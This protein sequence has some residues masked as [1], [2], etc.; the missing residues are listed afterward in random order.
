M[1]SDLSSHRLVRLPWDYPKIYQLNPD[2]QAV[3]LAVRASMAIPYFFEPY[4]L[5]HAVTHDD[6][7]VHSA[8]S[9]LVDGGMLSNFPVEVF[10]RKDG[11]EPR[12]PT[13]GIK[14]SSRGVDREKMVP[15]DVGGPL[16]Q[17]V[18]MLQTWSNFHDALHVDRADVVA[19][20][21]FVD[22]LGVSATDFD[23]DRTTQQKLYDSGRTAAEKFLSKWDFNGYIAEHRTVADDA[24]DAS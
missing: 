23:I 13:F 8:T 17:F 16:G 24:G 5:K 19:R 1:A 4:R 18:A 6:G 21:I 15:K 12:W 11:E 14:L 3:A 10:D 9:V 2:E 20:T 22:S 7:S